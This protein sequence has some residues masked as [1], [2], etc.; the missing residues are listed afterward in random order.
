MR[1]VLQGLRRSGD[2][3]D[4]LV[5]PSAEAPAS[6][7]TTAASRAPHLGAPLPLAGSRAGGTSR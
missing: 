5:T 1:A 7:Y 2:R 6:L 3:F 4:V